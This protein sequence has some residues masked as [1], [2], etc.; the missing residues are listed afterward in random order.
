MTRGWIVALGL[1]CA[2]SAWGFAAADHGCDA[3]HDRV[4]ERAEAALA[5]AGDYRPVRHP[6]RGLHRVIQA[7]DGLDLAIAS[8]RVQPGERPRRAMRQALEAKVGDVVTTALYRPEHHFFRDGRVPVVGGSPAPVGPSAEAF[9]AGARRYQHHLAM[10][11]RRAKE[12]AFGCAL[13][14]L[15][16]ALHGVQDAWSHTNLPEL[17]A[18]LVPGDGAAATARAARACLVPGAACPIPTL[19]AELRVSWFPAWEPAT[20]EGG[21]VRPEVGVSA[22]AVDCPDGRGASCYVRAGDAQAWERTVEAA[23]AELAGDGLPAEADYAHTCFSKETPRPVIAPADPEA[24]DRAWDAA[25]A[26]AEA[27][28]A[29][30]LGWAFAA[31]DGVAPDPGS[32]CREADLWDCVRVARP[33]ECAL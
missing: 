24:W 1:G 33:E 4:T 11:V 29:A 28:T 22:G 27:D 7:Q 21:P 25:V 15:G 20:P 14:D 8:A 12:N 30:A 26:G 31:L 32:R 5:R 16:L 10:A 9:A 6:E 13:I 2:G 23:C 17:T 19:G 18:G 3:V